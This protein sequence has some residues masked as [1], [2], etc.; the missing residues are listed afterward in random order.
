ME[1]FVKKMDEMDAHTLYDILELRMRVFIIEQQC[2][3]EELD[4]KDHDAT[5]VY[6]KDD[7]GKIVAYLRV[8]GHGIS[9]DEVSI[10]RVVVHPEARK[11]GLGRVLMH[12][13]IEVVK[14]LYGDTPIRISAQAYLQKFYKSL[15]FIAVSDIYL[16]DDIPHLDMMRGRQGDGDSVS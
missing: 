14:T 3:Y 11:D 7:S 12:K 2:F 4:H 10:G 13:G 1:W 8:L 6:A 15:G 16:E 9:F 5:H